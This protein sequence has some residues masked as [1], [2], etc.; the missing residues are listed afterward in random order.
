[1]NLQNLDSAKS[2]PTMRSLPFAPA[3][4]AF[5]PNGALAAAVNPA[6]LKQVI[7]F[8]LASDKPTPAPVTVAEPVADLVFAPNGQTLA[9]LHSTDWVRLFPVTGGAPMQIRTRTAVRRLAFQSDGTAF[10]AAGV[11]GTVRLWDARTGDEQFILTRSKRDV[12]DL[13]WSPN[14]QTLAI[15]IGDTVDLYDLGSRRKTFA[16]KGHTEPIRALAFNFDGTRVATAS[17]DGTVKLWDI[18]TGLETLTLR[19]HRDAVTFVA[20]T[21]DGKMLISQS[22]GDTRMWPTER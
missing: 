1:M 16:L 15:A 11:D 10:A 21:Q 4:L 3:A 13:A 18:A 14:D 17:E 9:T 8:A 5:A 22:D 6:G 7:F 2:A 20:F 19:G 12:A